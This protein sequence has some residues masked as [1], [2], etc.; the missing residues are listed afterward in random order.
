MNNNKQTKMVWEAQII[1]TRKRGCI[2]TT[3]FQGHH[4]DWFHKVIIVT[5]FLVKNSTN[6]IQK[7][8]YSSINTVT[9][10]VFLIK[11]LLVL[12]LKQNR[13][14][15]VVNASVLLVFLIIN[16]LTPKQ[17]LNNS[18]FF[19]IKLVLNVNDDSS[20]E[21]IFEGKSEIKL[22]WTDISS[23]NT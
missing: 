22:P 4:C 23:A 12:L 8:S 15:H 21:L 16:V 7:S 1:G 11:Y 10:F 20:S 3:H 5:E 17:P 14:M 18:C 6:T 9:V 13:K 2:T 19:E